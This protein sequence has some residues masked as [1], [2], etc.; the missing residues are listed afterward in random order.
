MELKTWE[1]KRNKKEFNS[2]HSNINHQN[3]PTL[4]NPYR[5]RL[6]ERLENTLTILWSRIIIIMAEKGK[7]N[8]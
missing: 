6:R 3:L 7:N 5:T 8:I 1:Q 4:F 2:I